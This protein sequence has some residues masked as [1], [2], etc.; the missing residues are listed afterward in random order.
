[1]SER[2]EQNVRRLIDEAWN[3][4]NLKV[5]DELLTPDHVNHDPMYP[6]RGVQELKDN[7]GKY[8]SAFPDLRCEIDE[9]LSVGDKVVARWHFTGTHKNQ[10]EGIPATGR[11]VSGTGISIQRF[12]GD[13]VQETYVNFDALGM[14]QQLGVV[15]L[16]G[17]TSAAG[18]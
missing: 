5:L 3:K 18:R 8:R 7:I 17:K 10:F 1:M 12:A 4:G 14:M 9:L 13:K 11:R 2:Y 15:T 16:P 6:T